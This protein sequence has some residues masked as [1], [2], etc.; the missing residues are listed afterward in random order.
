MAESLFISDLHLCEERPATVALF[1]TFMRQR[2]P[3]A[4][5]LYML[6][7]IFE[8]WVG[9]D[10]RSAVN[11]TVEQHIA[12][13]ATKGVQVFFMV[14][15]RDFLLGC[16]FAERTGCEILTDPSVVDVCGTDTLLVHGDSLC[17]DDRAHQTYRAQAYSS[18]WKRA[19]LAKPLEER[20]AIAR[21]YRQASMA[22]NQLKSDSIMDVNQDTVVQVM[23]ERKVHRLIHGHTHRPAVHDFEIDGQPAQRIVLAQW[24][25]Q[26]SVLCWDHDGYHLE[27]VRA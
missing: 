18:E 16:A 10:D 20:L 4:G 12:E 13:V 17:T 11:L 26:G 3:R 9:D 25:N 23:R 1:E 24:E 6:G 27:T 21:Q 14:G 5:T 22:G 8:A 7:D 19:M 2:A 15:N